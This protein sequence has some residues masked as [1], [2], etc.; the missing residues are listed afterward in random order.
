MSPSILCLD[1]LY[2][3]MEVLCPSLCCGLQTDCRLRSECVVMERERTRGLSRLCMRRS[4]WLHWSMQRT[5]L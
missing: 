5:G 1:I 2:M 3:F 4:P